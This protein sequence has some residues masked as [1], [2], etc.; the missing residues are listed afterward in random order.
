[1]Y[2]AKWIFRKHEETP[3]TEV[4]INRGFA[5][6]VYLVLATFDAPTQTASLAVDINPLVNWVWMG[7]GLLALG[8][9]IA[10]LPDAVFSFATAPIPANAATTAL[11][12]LAVVLS[13]GVVFAQ[14][15]IPAVFRSPLERRVASE[16]MC[17]CGGCRLSVADCGMMNCHGKS[18]QSAKIHQYIAAGQEHDA[19]LATF[20]REHGGYDVLM[21][22]PN[23]GF[24]RVA[25]LLPYVVAVAALVGVAFTAK[26]WSRR[27][28]AA[29][30]AA[31]ID[32]ELDARLE[33][34]LRDLD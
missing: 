7:F 24:N 16:I 19:I 12:L 8:I 33:D 13:Q 20:V 26:R 2:P 9:G 14:D 15:T 22:P 5:Q 27:E 18:S 34:E 6:D 30:T 29:P 25:W 23:R 4:A 32:P 3:T 10:L 11:I 28:G 17:N 31:A 1:M 21:Q